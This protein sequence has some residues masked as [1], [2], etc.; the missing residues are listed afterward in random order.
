MRFS[1]LKSNPNAIIRKK[2]YKKGKTWIVASMLSFASGFILFAGGNTVY[3]DQDVNTANSTTSNTATNDPN[4]LKSNDTNTTDVVSN[5]ESK[6]INTSVAVNT[7]L[8]VINI[9]VNG[10]PNSTVTVDV[11]AKS[12]YTANQNQISV[13]IDSNGV[14][15]TEDSIVYNAVLDSHNTDVPVASDFEEAR[16]GDIKQKSNNDITGKDSSQT[17]IKESNKDTSDPND[18][19]TVNGN[20]IVDSNLGD[21]NIPV[22]G[23]KGGTFTVDIPNENPTYKKYKLTKSQ[24]ISGKI[25]DDGNII[26]DHPDEFVF[27]DVPNGD[28]PLGLWQKSVSIPVYIGNSTYTFETETAPFQDSHVAYIYNEGKTN[29]PLTQ[30]PYKFK[31]GQNISFGNE[32]VGLRLSHGKIILDDWREQEQSNHEGNRMMMEVSIA[33][34]NYHFLD[35]EGKPIDKGNYDGIYNTVIDNNWDT[36]RF[37]HFDTANNGILSLPT[38]EIH[39]PGYTV[40]DSIQLN[41]I[42]DVDNDM[43]QSIRLEKAEPIHAT[44]QTYINGKIKDDIKDDIPYNSLFLDADPK[45]TSISD[46]TVDLDKSYFYMHGMPDEKGMTFKELKDELSKDPE[47]SSF[48]WDEYSDTSSPWNFYKSY[49]GFAFED[50]IKSV[51]WNAIYW[52]PS[53]GPLKVVEYFTKEETPQKPVTDKPKPNKPNSSHSESDNNVS[54]SD[55]MQN[56]A[57]FSDKPTVT[58]YSISGNEIKPVEN[59]ALAPNTDWYSDKLAKISDG[60]MQYYRVA[61]NE[62]VRASDV[63][64]YETV[65]D[66]VTTK[67]SDVP[68]IA[69][70]GTLV[71]NRELAP[72]TS[73][74][75]DRIGYL[76]TG[77]K[78]DAFYRVATNEFVNKNDVTVGKNQI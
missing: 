70:E 21:V 74:R 20:V 24:S 7:N 72:E 49:M 76:G 54:I 67:N 13:N 50:Y 32:Y 33:N 28:D 48:S 17:G 66:I 36:D 56:I 2:M 27:Y 73:W 4:Q 46:A 31:D 30:E 63:H 40:P 39:I 78:P 77:D 47:Y 37:T 44:F 42:F 69:A 3:A 6:N 43:T 29:I 18:S 75:V 51:D 19:N 38:D 35:S 64:P 16:R 52:S 26:T 8:G 9:A 59:R 53:F 61:T 60:D 5:Q 11:P 71:K 1:Q 10:S 22:S 25:D 23:V 65:N 41:H 55:L 12:G 34:I 68:L 45:M 15:T 14:A 57:T 62:W 58:L